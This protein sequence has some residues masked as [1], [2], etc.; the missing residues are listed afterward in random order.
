MASGVHGGRTLPLRVLVCSL[1][2]LSFCTSDASPRVRHAVAPGPG[3][4]TAAFA[5]PRP[6]LWEHRGPTNHGLA[7][8]P[9]GRA[10]IPCLPRRM[11]RPLLR[12]MAQSGATAAFAS[13]YEQVEVGEG[14]EIRSAPPSVGGFGRFMGNLDLLRESLDEQ[15]EFVKEKLQVPYDELQSQIQPKEEQ[16][17]DLRR[18]FEE[19][20]NNIFGSQILPIEVKLAPLLKKRDLIA[21]DL[22]YCKGAMEFWES[23]YAEALA[24]RQESGE[25]DVWLSGRDCYVTVE[26]GR[27]FA[28][29]SAAEAALEVSGKAGGELTV[30]AQWPT[31]RAAQPV[32]VDERAGGARLVVSFAAPEEGYRKLCA[33]AEWT[34][35]TKA[36]DVRRRKRA[37]LVA[38]NMV[39]PPAP[40]PPS[41]KAFL[42]APTLA[43]TTP[44]PPPPT[45][46]ATLFERIYSNP[47]A[48]GAS[49]AG[50]RRA[51][52]PGRAHGG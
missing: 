19:T 17:A 7:P 52:R 48:L 38:L 41:R 21:K 18:K 6:G 37:L 9:A 15:I 44:P 34:G 43:L 51:A 45:H 32:L 30:Q 35:E 5:P 10:Q 8:R 16:L 26:V 20:E 25:A 13:L 33:V 11:N 28:L 31:A 1:A 12:R 46:P 36:D 2:A 4:V 27:S 50:L 42:V 24:L 22:A 14:F 40:H 39:P 29:D 3:C 49:R 23:H 47:H